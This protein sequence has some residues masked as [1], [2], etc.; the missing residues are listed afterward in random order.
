M[1]T[2]GATGGASSGTVLRARPFRQRSFE[3]NSVPLQRLAQHLVQGHAGMSV[4]GHGGDLG[5]LRRG[6]VALIGDQ[7]I[8]RR[9]AGRESL[10]VGL[11]QLLL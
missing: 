6:Q 9:A 7:I 3:R 8:E 5:Q 4:S 1:W 2:F 10:L 11:Q